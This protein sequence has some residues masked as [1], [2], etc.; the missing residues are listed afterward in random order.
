MS[1]IILDNAG[2]FFD[3]LNLMK[4]IG[5]GY[6]YRVYEFDN[7]RV[8]KKLQPHW[9]SFRK[10]YSLA[11]KRSGTSVIKSL[12]IA[13]KS[14]IEERK[15]LSAMKNRLSGMPLSLF[16]NPSFVKDSLDYT[17]DRVVIMEDFFLKNNLEQNKKAIDGYV[18][19]Q[20]KLWSYGIYD[21]TDKLQTNYGVNKQGG[22]VCIDFG[23]FVF[24]KEKALERVKKQKWLSRQSYKN[25]Q[26][27]GL[28]KYYTERMIKVITEESLNKI[29]QCGI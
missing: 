6:Y 20:K 4:H 22:V 10:I 7:G 3:I 16:A 25:W 5:E 12:S 24:T 13:Y 8:F 29:W 15:N 26:D 1:R 2:H 9:F 19:F 18:E 11:R 17:Q 23:E 28:K 21:T 27:L 14:T